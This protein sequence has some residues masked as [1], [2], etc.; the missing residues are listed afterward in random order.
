[1]VAHGERLRVYKIYPLRNVLVYNGT[2]ILHYALGAFGLNLGYDR[3]PVLGW[4]LALG[5]LVF[6]LAQMY[7]LMPLS[8]CPSCV[9]RRLEGARCV[10]GLNLLSAKFARQADAKDFPNR[11]KGFL[12]HNHLYMASLA[13][14]LILMLP[15]LILAFSAPLLFV[16]LAVVGLFVFR[17]LVVFPRVACGRCAAKGDCPN[18]KA[19]GLS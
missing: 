3:W 10:S 1:V 4:V 2:T 17:V 13:A 12:C 14:P 19:M 9:Y 5:Y 18:A 15:A 16:F 6:A 8:V 7:V 11:G